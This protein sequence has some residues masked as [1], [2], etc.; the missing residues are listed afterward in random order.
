M[1]LPPVKRSSPD[2]EQDF[3]VDFD[4]AFANSLLSDNAEFQA[5]SQSY[6]EA[7]NFYNSSHGSDGGVDPVLH[8]YSSY[9]TM[10]S[11]ASSSEEDAILEDEEEDGHGERAT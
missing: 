11:S 9:D 10:Q 2:L 6:M 4:E 5:V 8:G 7:L 1:A 3:C